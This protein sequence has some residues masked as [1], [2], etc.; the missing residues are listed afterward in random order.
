MNSNYERD[1]NIQGKSKISKRNK[2]L[3][4]NSI[5]IFKSF[6]ILWAPYFWICDGVGSLSSCTYKHCYK[7]NGKEEP[8]ILHSALFH[9][10]LHDSERSYHCPRMHCTFRVPSSLIEPN[11]INNL[12][13]EIQCHN[14]YHKFEEMVQF[15]LNKQK[16]TPNNEIT[17]WYINSGGTR[18]KE[19]YMLAKILESEKQI[20]IFFITESN[21]RQNYQMNITG[22]KSHYIY[23]VLGKTLD[24]VVQGISGGI[25]IYTHDSLLVMRINIKKWIIQNSNPGDYMDIKNSTEEYLQMIALSIQKV[26]DQN[27]PTLIVLCYRSPNKHSVTVASLIGGYLTFINSHMKPFFESVMIIGDF[28]FHAEWK[29]KQFERI[30]S[31]DDNSKRIIG[32]WFITNRG[33]FFQHQVEPTIK[34]EDNPPQILDL[35][36]T[37]FKD[38]ITLVETDKKFCHLDEYE[39]STRHYLLKSSLIIQAV[40]ATSTECEIIK[41]FEEMTTMEAPKLNY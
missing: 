5:N 10:S 40:K 28:N 13:Y 9:E 6:D 30:A 36:I 7:R 11:N 2:E 37:N 29:V 25:V 39:F 17:F 15:R 4:N 22:Y 18:F 38:N 12:V 26:D 33:M 1:T 3:W 35:I 14:S 19:S 34:H 23:G 16:K 32:D 31:Y 21:F 8:I 20:D 27:K 24:G 41:R